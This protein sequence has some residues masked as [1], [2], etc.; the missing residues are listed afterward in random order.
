MKTINWIIVPFRWERGTDINELMKRCKINLRLKNNTHYV[1]FI[2][3]IKPE[4]TKEKVDN[5]QQCWNVDDFGGLQKYHPIS[6]ED[7]KM[8]DR[9]FVGWITE[10]FNRPK[11][12][13]PSNSIKFN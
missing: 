3:V 8:I 4:A 10:E 6:D 7:Q 11:G 9:L 1:R 2:G 5:L 13:L 12:V